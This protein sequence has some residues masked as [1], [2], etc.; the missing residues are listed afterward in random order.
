MKHKVAS[1]F[2]EKYKSDKCPNCGFMNQN[3][4]FIS[5]KELACYM[6]GTVFINYETRTA[7]RTVV[8]QMLTEQE[9]DRSSWTCQ[10]PGCTFGDGGGVFKAKSKAGLKAHMKKHEK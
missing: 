1:R 4:I 5:D 3:F 8:K 7:M 10:H 9:E 2:N 6:C